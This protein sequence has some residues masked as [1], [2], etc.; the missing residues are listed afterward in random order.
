MSWITPLGF[1]GLLGILIL[2]LI[3]LLK[4]NYQQK[5]VSSTYVWKLSLKYRKKR[6]PV[7]RLRNILIFI[8]QILIITSCAFILA[9]PAKLIEVPEEKSEKIVIIDA[10]ANMLA[11][12]GDETRFERAVSQVKTLAG[13]VAKD[14]GVLTVILA[15]AKASYVV[16]RSGSSLISETYSKMDELVNPLSF[17]CSYGSGDIS[18]AMTL[19]EKILA[20]NSDADVLLYT[21]TSYIDKG[22]VTVVDVSAEG[23]WNT[24]IL[25]C[26]STVEDNYYTFNVQVASYGKDVDAILYCEI[27]DANY[28]KIDYQLQANIRFSG[29]NVVALTMKYD[30]SDSA[31]EVDFTG[32]FIQQDGVWYIPGIYSFE[33]IYFRLEVEGSEDSFS[34][35]DSFYVYGGT[36]P[37]IR[38]QYASSAPNTFF[39]AI[40]RNYRSQMTD[41]SIEYKQ[42]ESSSAEIEGYDFYIF[43]H[44][45]P[46]TLPTDGVVLLVDP[47][48][49]PDGLSDS[50]Q[51]VD[52]VSGDFTLA[53]GA[54]HA[55]TKY[56][57]AENIAI[58]QYK[59]LNTD[60]TFDGLLFCGGDPILLLRNTADSKVAILSLDLN[61]STLALKEDFPLLM[62]NLFNY[63][64]PTT[65]SQ[66]A[67]SVNESVELNAR[68]PVLTVTGQGESQTFETFPSVMTFSK[69]G[70]Y[71]LTQTPISGTE[72]IENVFVKIP[73]TESNILRQEDTLVGPYIERQVESQ[74]L[75]LVIYFAIALVALLFLEW[76]LHSREQL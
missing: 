51:I 42:V 7:N 66:N 58:T 11:K 59:Q 45:M 76:L 50:V 53:P 49:I 69:P 38:I 24:G 52:T 32:S 23:E 9:Q 12:S 2:I 57:T 74:N 54:S 22:N 63:F 1:L 44:S 71:T 8:C 15:G 37:T 47:D 61:R 55:V 26:T 20:E 62:F 34:Y 48:I 17:A 29:D 46:T 10:S 28:D 4:P 56:M 30:G 65:I 75:D 67:Y 16:Q 35:D 70:T 73:A 27:N 19:A 5:L 72:T 6:L 43:E 41:W 64:I 39:N 33:Y 25:E 68:G 31:N 18:G 40:L 3:Y 14:D 36:K 60:D 13:D 21:A